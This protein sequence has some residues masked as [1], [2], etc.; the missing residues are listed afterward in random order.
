M[1]AGRHE[2]ETSCTAPASD[3]LMAAT[4][5]ILLHGPLWRSAV[6]QHLCMPSKCSAVAGHVCS[7]SLRAVSKPQAEKA[8]TLNLRSAG[9]AWPGG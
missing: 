4:W 2:A 1:P 5:L 9:R 7:S 3:L 8:E 6:M